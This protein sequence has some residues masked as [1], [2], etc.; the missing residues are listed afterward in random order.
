MKK[1]IYQKNLMTVTTFSKILALLL[2]ILLI[3][4]S[5]FLGMEYK[6]K[7]YMILNQKLSLSD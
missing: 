4:A 2:F 6:E 7:E 3:F 5:F 1:N